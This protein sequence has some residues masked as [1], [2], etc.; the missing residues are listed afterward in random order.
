MITSP[1]ADK[2]SVIDGIG[3]STGVA[4]F[5]GDDGR[6]Y[7]LVTTFSSG[8]SLSVVDV[9]DPNRIELVA[10]ITNDD[11]D[12][13]FALSFPQDVATVRIG[14]HQYA[15][16]ATNSAQP[17]KIFNVTD[18]SE[19][20]AV[21]G[22]D[23]G[24]LHERV[25]ARTV[26]TALIDGR[27][28]AIIGVGIS[29][30]ASVVGG[31]LVVDITDPAH[32]STVHAQPPGQGSLAG[33]FGRTSLSD[34]VRIGEGHYML[35]Y[36]GSDRHVHISNITDPTN[37]QIISKISDID[38]RASTIL[39][40]GGSHY[41]L[42]SHDGAFLTTDI[43]D[44]AAPSTTVTLNHTALQIG[45]VM[46]TAQIGDDYYALVLTNSNG[47]IIFNVTDPTRPAHVG[48]AAAGTLV[49]RPLGHCAHTDRPPPL[50]A[51]LG[52]GLKFCQQ[53]QGN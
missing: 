51:G 27:H 16:V 1:V 14:N 6:Q 8:A 53:L 18:P 29:T 41:V 37:P 25:E 11:V 38:P 46:T 15:L 26:V 13:D 17:L 48:V 40:V 36:S 34:T 32:P 44:P 23:T 21:A 2:Q 24:G 43:T 4:V 28:Y 22:S 39:Q 7:A 45:Y 42:T 5:Q 50:H 31:L 9:T 12:D 49:G 33:T 47:I 35:I 19:P 10:M 3:A 20:K 52:W 30:S